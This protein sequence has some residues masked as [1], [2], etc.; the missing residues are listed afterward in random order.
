M[1]GTGVLRVIV[2]VVRRAIERKQESSEETQGTIPE[3]R[4][5]NLEHEIPQER[6]NQ[7]QVTGSSYAWRGEGK[8][9]ISK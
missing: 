2:L 7:R 4:Q 3:V 6:V 5:G 9:G 8:A 1:A